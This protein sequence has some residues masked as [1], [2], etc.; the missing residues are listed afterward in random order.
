[1]QK[2]IQ[3]YQEIGQSLATDPILRRVYDTI[4]HG[5]FNCA[6]QTPFVFINESSGA[7]KT[8]ASFALQHLIGN[9]RKFIYILGSRVTE[10]SQSV[11]KAFSDIT[12]S[13]HNCLDF[14]MKGSITGD[15]TSM[16]IFKLHSLPLYTFGFFYNILSPSDESVQQSPITRKTSKDVLDVLK[17]HNMKRPVVVLDEFPTSS[18]HL[19]DGRLRLMRNCIRTLNIVL[20]IMGTNA[21]AANLVDQMEQSRGNDDNDPWCFLYPRL[22]KIRIELL[23]LPK[24]LQNEI[25]QVISSSRPLFGVFAAEKLPSNLN[26]SAEAIDDW[27]TEIATHISDSK[28]I[29]K[30]KFGRHGQ[31]CLFLNMSYAYAKKNQNYTPLINHHFAQLVDSDCVELNS[32]LQISS[33]AT[34]KPQCRYPS[35][36]EDILLFLCLMGTLNFHPFKID[37]KKI[38]YSKAILEIIK[39]HQRKHLLFMNYNN[40]MQSC[41]DGMFLEALLAGILCVASRMRGVKG[42]SLHSYLSAIWSHLLVTNDPFNEYHLSEHSVSPELDS[43]LNTFI[44]PILAPPNQKWPS[45]LKNIP[46]IN[47]GILERPQNINGVDI[48]TNFKLSG[49]CKDYESIIP[50]PVMKKIINR[51]PPETCVHIVFVRHLQKKYHK[52][53]TDKEISVCVVR[54]VDGLDEGH[55]KLELQNINGMPTIDE[56]TS[57]HKLVVFFEVDNVLNCL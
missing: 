14:D 34:W 16:S 55:I 32:K 20:I 38:S 28:S 21:A 19:A 12:D 11:Y 7:G 50:L 3:K 56:Y 49:E 44:I 27:L 26:F 17:S 8:Q 29:F 2:T 48:L 25:V 1:M 51:I 57:S 37:E 18:G 40:A 41:N 42:I 53:S 30:N 10:Q 24:N 31:I 43:F 9:S 6:G 15:I 13:F 33:G 54:A 23:N 46:Q 35:P 47:S 45:F 36:S 39:L 22:P 4:N 52:F 5:A